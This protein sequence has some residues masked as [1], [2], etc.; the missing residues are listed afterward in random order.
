MYRII[1]FDVDDTLLDFKA[2]ELK[3]LAKMFAR[4]NLTYSPRI[5]ASYLKINASLWRDYEAGRITR[6]ELFDVRFAK[7]FRHH[8]IEADPHLAERTYHHFLDQ[9]AFLLPR[10]L[11]TLDAL[12]D[13]RLFIVSNGIEPVQ[14]ERLASS[15]LIDY[16]EDIFVSDS[17]GSPKPTVAFFDYVAKRIPRF[18]RRETLIM[19]DSL[20]SDIQGGI[21]GKIDSIWFNPHFQPNRD[22]ITP[23]YQLN[24]FSDLTK[25][26]TLN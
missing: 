26:L 9:E 8:H 1:L 11:D 4:L 21:N 22:H 2:G 13:Y 14:R 6:P 25:L 20:T 24:E 3:S 12:Q 16:F 15:G 19:G 10:V 5:E 18:D 7:L 23:T 17:V